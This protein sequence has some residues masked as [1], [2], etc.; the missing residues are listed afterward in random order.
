MAKSVHTVF[1]INDTWKGM[2][3]M[4]EGVRNIGNLCNQIGEEV[5][6]Q[7]SNETPGYTANKERM[8]TTLENWLY[9]VSIRLDVYAQRTKN[10]VLAALV[11]FSRSTLST[12]ALNKLLGLAKTVQRRTGELLPSLEPFQITQT[13]IDILRTAIMATEETNAYRD[14]VQSEH[15][16]NTEQLELLFNTLRMELDLMDKQVEAFIKDE[17]FI[18]IYFA[19]RRIHDVRGGGRKTEEE[20]EE[21]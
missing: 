1:Q 2:P 13:D 15:I 19:A 7:Q 9:S 4:E 16:G 21:I 5:V 11:N 20:E 10:D 14:A 8:R 18:R 17:E 3:L 6:K 12:M